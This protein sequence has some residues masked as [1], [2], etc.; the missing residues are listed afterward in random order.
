MLNG[1]VFVDS[2]QFVSDTLVPLAKG[3]AA[4]GVFC[5]VAAV[6]SLVMLLGVSAFGGGVVALASPVTIATISIASFAIS[7]YVTSEIFGTDSPK[8]RNE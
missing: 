2:L 4:F 3:A 6:S 1:S 8:E 7:S 5:G